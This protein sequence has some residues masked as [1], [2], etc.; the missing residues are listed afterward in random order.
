MAKKQSSDK[1]S[2][3]ASLVLSKKKTPTEAEARQLAACVLGQ[4][5]T[6]GKRKK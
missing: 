1:M 3:L 5:E 4:D 2:T 6:K